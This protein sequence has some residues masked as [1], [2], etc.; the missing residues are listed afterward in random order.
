MPRQC[1]K[2]SDLKA[3]YR[4]LSNEA[5]DPRSIGQ[6]HQQ[7]TKSTCAG[8]PLV[9]CVQDDTHLSGR[10]DRMQH[11]TLAVLPDGRLLG[12][13]D[14][15]FFQRVQTPAGETRLEREAR[16]RESCV[17]T[18]AAKA[19]GHAPMG[20]RFVHV[21]DRA[22]DDLNFME[23]CEEEEAGFVLSRF[24][25]DHDR[26]INGGED[27]LWSFMHKQSSCGMITVRIGAQRDETGRIMRR[28][29]TAEVSIRFAKVVL[30]PPHNHPGDHAPRTVWSVYLHEDASPAGEDAVDWMLLTS[31]RVASEGEARAIIGFYERRW[32]IEE[33]HRAL[34]E[35]CRVEMSLLD[36]PED[37]LRLAALLS[38]VAVRLLQ[39][40]DLADP[41]HA[42]AEDAE[43]L[44]RWAPAT[45]IAMVAKL[46][47]HEA[48]TLTP[49]QFML[50][51][52]KRGGY[53]DRK[54]DPRPGWKVLWRGW[55]DISLLV[56]GA[57]LRCQ[58]PLPT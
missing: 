29:R 21:S 8:Y 42:E 57:E 17:W 48:R 30:E 11:T 45:W 14:Q 9:L 41:S 10:C 23:A 47:G 37:H 55:Y 44:H 56:E 54:H 24:H 31:E 20:R 1:E 40:R 15:R 16:W 2:W 46:G 26:R 53:L 22:S 32:V 49:R 39:L 50:T 52:A 3:A 58:R 34:K 35:G 43:A 5:V 13:L 18:E 19:I 12:I 51:I 7:L 36:D 6:P 38:V 33:W 4:L 27:R 25:R 28:Q